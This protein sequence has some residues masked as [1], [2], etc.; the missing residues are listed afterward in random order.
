MGTPAQREGNLRLKVVK[1]SLPDFDSIDVW[2]LADTHIGDI[3]SDFKKLQEILD[4]VKA[5]ENAYLIL[6]GDLVDLAVRNSIG[7]IYSQNLT[8]MQGLE[9]CVKIFEP[10][11]DKVLCV[12]PG[13]HELRV[14]RTDGI[15]FTKLLCAQLGIADR[16]SN[17]STLLFLRFGTA[18]KKTHH[19]RPQLY[20]LY[21]AHGS[22]TG[23]TEG[24]KINRLVQL[25]AIIDA[26]CYVHSHTHLPVVTKNAYYRVCTSNNSAQKIER[27]FVN[28]GSLLDYG[29]YGEM[30]NYKP[31]S[32]ETPVIH[33]N[34]RKREL[35]ATL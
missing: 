31:N 28:T 32:L 10:V 22:G 7:D 15:D 33:L 18:S 5:Q 27:L 30:Q 24:A 11:A 29:G 13:N 20:S 9:Q 8:P 35:T 25:S 16:Y 4:R 2:P 21:C 12:Q 26:D 6:N 1:H 34:G 19:G 17:A 23:R 14:W 3:H